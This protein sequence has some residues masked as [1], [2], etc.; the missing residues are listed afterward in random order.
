M[1]SS[2]RSGD[3]VGGAELEAEVGAGLVAAHE[4]DLAGLEELGRDHRAQAHGTVTDDG[5][6][7]PG[8]HAGNLRGVVVGRHDVGEAGQRRDERFV[9]PG[10]DGDERAGCLRHPDLL[11]LTAVDAVG[12]PVGTVTARGLQTFLA[13]RQRCRQ[14]C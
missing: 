11:A 12:T 6:R 2:P 1:S 8:L 9:E 3:D 4:D 14:R 10:R 5:D 7:L 13:P